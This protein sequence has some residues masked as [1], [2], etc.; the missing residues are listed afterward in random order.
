M[1]QLVQSKTFTNELSIDLRAMDAGLYLLQIEAQ[2]TGEQ[3]VKKL[4]LK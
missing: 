2:N 1:G 3:V 4:S